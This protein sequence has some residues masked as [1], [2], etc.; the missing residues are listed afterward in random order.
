MVSFEGPDATASRV[1]SDARPGV[2]RAS[3]HP[4]TPPP[5]SSSGTRRA[6]RGDLGGGEAAPLVQEVS[7]H[8]GAGVYEGE[9]AK[10]DT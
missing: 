6:A 9:W 10:L 3:R 2:T 4:A 1:A 7:Q 5:S 8:Y